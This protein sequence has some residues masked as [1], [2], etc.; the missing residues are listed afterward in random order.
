MTDKEI[1]TRI[2]TRLMEVTDFAQKQKG[3]VQFSSAHGISSERAKELLDI[4]QKKTDSVEQLGTY[5]LVL[6]V[7]AETELTFDECLY[8]IS[9]SAAYQMS[10]D[11][12]Q[13]SLMNMLNSILGKED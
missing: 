9:Q 12:R 5:S 4:A 8:M 7:A 6:A 13:N 10:Q 11:I 3:E 1:V 2:V